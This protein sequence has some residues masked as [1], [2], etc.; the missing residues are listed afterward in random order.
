[1]M[2]AKWCLENGRAD[3]VIEE[4]KKD[5]KTYYKINDFAKL[6]VLFGKLL[7]E[8]QRIKSTGDYEGAK[9]LVETYGVKV[10]PTIHAEVLKRYESLDV[11]RS[12]G[13]VN[14]R[15]TLKLDENSNVVDVLIDYTQGYTE[16]MLE[17]SRLYSFEVPVVE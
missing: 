7:A 11:P 5:G 4:I 8:I 17:C 6:R 1:M 16:Q 3:N 13:F 14:P 15:Y 9:N 2:I 12:K 10:D